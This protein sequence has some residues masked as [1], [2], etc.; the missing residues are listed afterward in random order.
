MTH[1]QLTDH[2]LLSK[3]DQS[4]RQCKLLQIY[5]KDVHDDY[6]KIKVA[7]LK[8]EFAKHEYATLLREA[9]TRKLKLD[10]QHSM[11]KML[12]H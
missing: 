5:L 7:K 6:G 1:N 8:F 11:F 10:E 9:K 3:L 4:I 2:A 12:F